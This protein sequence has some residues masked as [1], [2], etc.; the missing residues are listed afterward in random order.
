MLD[1][2]TAS[3][4]EAE[5]RI[6]DLG[7]LDGERSEVVAMN[8]NGQV[9]GHFYTSTGQRHA[10]FQSVK[11]KPETL[12]HLVEVVGINARGETAGNCGGNQCI[13]FR[14]NSERGMQPLGH[15]GGGWSM[16]TA[17]GDGGQ[18]VG[19]SRDSKMHT[20]GF[21]WTEAGGMTPLGKLGQA[22]AR[23]MAVNAAGVVVGA[24]HDAQGAMRA[25]RWSAESGMQDLKVPGACSYA[26]AIN[27]AGQI[28]GRMRTDAGYHAFLWEPGQQV[29][30]LGTLGGETTIP[31]ALTEAGT[32]IGQSSLAEGA[33]HAFTWSADTGIKDLGSL[34][35]AE[36]CARGV[37][38][39]GQVVG[40]SQTAEGRRQ[41]FVWTRERGMQPLGS[42][43]GDG[44]RALRI[45][46]AGVIAGNACIP[47]G[48]T[49]ACLWKPVPDVETA[50][51]GP[52]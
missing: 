10:F 21:V 46:D 39:L 45:S 31:L 11:Q 41:A 8:A 34:G 20:Y 51:L 19:Q 14:W 5:Y 22:P 4:T 49:H 30:D 27:A 32:V 52:R 28:V 48:Q 42:L 29:R 37:N 9:A 7:T 47:S 15:L 3:A 13:A 38:N 36:S 33:S 43:G 17:I 50:R 25:F 1:L 12:G 24:S 6:V 26:T 2:A 44:C 35:G 18:V 40:W 23:P 16:A